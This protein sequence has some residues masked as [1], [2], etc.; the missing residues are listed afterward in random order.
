MKKMPFDHSKEVINIKLEK[1]L[2]TLNINTL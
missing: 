1:V 2:D